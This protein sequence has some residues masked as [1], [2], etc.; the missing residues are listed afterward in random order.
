MVVF[1]KT[2]AERLKL[3]YDKPAQQWVEALPVG[4]GRLGAMVFGNPGAERIQLNEETVW[5]GHPNSNARPDALEAMPKIRELIFAGKY[6]EAQDMTGAR[7]ISNTN[8]YLAAYVI[9]IILSF[10]LISLDRFSLETNLTAVLACFNNIGPGLDAVG[11]TCNYGHYSDFSKLIL[12]VDM[13]SGR[14]EIFPV[15]VLFSRNSWRKR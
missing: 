9:I 2:D 11:P 3:W 12:C 5:T 15:L 6:R 10:L 13:L 14:L 8:A 7:V 4:N 1:G